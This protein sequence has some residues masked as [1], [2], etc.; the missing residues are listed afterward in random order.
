MGPDQTETRILTL[1]DVASSLQ[2]QLH[3]LTLLNLSENHF[4]SQILYLTGHSACTTHAFLIGSSQRT[5]SLQ[6]LQPGCAS[7]CLQSEEPSFPKSCPFRSSASSSC[8]IPLSSV[9]SLS[10][11]TLCLPDCRDLLT[12]PPLSASQSDTRFLL[13]TGYLHLESQISQCAMSFPDS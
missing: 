2:S 4:T 8:P 10:S 7:S 11:G 12:F 5:T 9:L 3:I 13:S 6:R 1:A